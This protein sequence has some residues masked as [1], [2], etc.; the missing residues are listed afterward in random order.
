M[1]RAQH[2]PLRTS[3]LET[4]ETSTVTPCRDRRAQPPSKNPSHLEELSRDRVLASTQNHGVEGCGRAARIYYVFF[5]GIVARQAHMFN[6]VMGSCFGCVR[7]M[8][9]NC[10]HACVLLGIYYDF[11]LW[12]FML[13]L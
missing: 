6:D 3:L 7:L 2:S 1:K 10:K 4:N 9:S 5:R 13:V 8:W 11:F 12:Q